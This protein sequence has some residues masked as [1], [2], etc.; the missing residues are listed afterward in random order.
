M[1]ILNSTIGFF[2]TVGSVGQ[3]EKVGNMVF[4]LPLMGGLLVLF[5]SLFSDIKETSWILIF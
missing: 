2:W 3:P 5:Y 4:R 1:F